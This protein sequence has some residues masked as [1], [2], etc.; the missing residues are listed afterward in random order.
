MKSKLTTSTQVSAQSS[1]R[2]GATIDH[3]IIHHAAMFDL[4]DCVDLMVSGRKQVSSNYVVQGK[5]IVSVVPEELRAFTSGS[6]RDGG[7]GA[8]WDRRSMTV[9]TINST[10]EPNW[11]ISEETFQS[12][13]ALVA[14]VA[15]RYNFPID[16]E[17]I[18][19]HRELYTRYGASYATACPGGIPLDRLVARAR[20]LQKVATQPVPAPKPI[21]ID[22]EE[23]PMRL[24]NIPGGGIVLSGPGGT[25][26]VFTPEHV[27]LLVRW[28][29]GKNTLDTRETFYQSQ[30]DV[31]T[32]YLARVS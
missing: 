31:I 5:R 9:E 18:I 22:E 30:L 12:L 29:N 28:F 15:T 19:G 11:L 10:G 13:A 3:F 24:I 16:R 2:Q 1:S 20:E 26:P 14:D 6:S 21:V 7:K 25:T 23:I 32:D 17:H 8:A 27:G 4:D